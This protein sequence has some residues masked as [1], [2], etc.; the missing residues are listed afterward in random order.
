MPPP[1]RRGQHRGGKAAAT[2]EFRVGGG[3]LIAGPTQHAGEGAQPTR[4]TSPC[5]RWCASPRDSGGGTVVRKRRPPQTSGGGWP[6][7][8]RVDPARWRG[9]LTD[10][11]NSLHCLLRRLCLFKPR[12]RVWYR[13]AHGSA[14]VA[15]P[16]QPTPSSL[17][18]LPNPPMT[19]AC[20][21]RHQGGECLRRRRRRNCPATPDGMHRTH[22]VTTAVELGIPLAIVPEH[23]V[24]R[25]RRDAAIGIVELRRRI[26]DCAPCS[27]PDKPVA[28]T[29]V[30]RI[31]GIRHGC[32]C[33]CT[34]LVL[35]SEV[36]DSTRQCANMVESSPKS[37][38]RYALAVNTPDLAC[39]SR[40]IRTAE[41]LYVAVPCQ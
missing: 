1:G 14:T 35:S 17:S 40:S 28:L 20:T 11:A 25:A 33:R 12:L 39:C 2:P 34:R 3:C 7:D 37:A 16:R 23:A 36:V 27:Q 5:C 41:P 13:S 26:G 18:S 8:C 24:R 19:P 32:R 31:V 29:A 10:P 21:G 6:P 4:A 22:P 15:A 30:H 9:R 38:A